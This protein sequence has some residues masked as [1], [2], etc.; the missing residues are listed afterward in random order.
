MYWR[1]ACFLTMTA[2][3]TNTE[4]TPLLGPH[5]RDQRG[6]ASRA[7][8]ERIL[9]AIQPYLSLFQSEGIPSNDNWCPD[10]LSAETDRTAFCLLV[11]LVYKAFL[12]QQ[13]RTEQDFWEQWSEEVGDSASLRVIETRMEG[14]W[15][16]F[17]TVPRT[18]ADV[19]QVL[20]KGFPARGDN[21]FLRI[22]GQAIPQACVLL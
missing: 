6:A 16:K 14:I 11:F 10:G 19:N 8:S 18:A 17:L 12:K 2:Q 1:C 5:A 9:P 20:W 4:T 22:R 3:P 15:E 13:T 21:A 7:H